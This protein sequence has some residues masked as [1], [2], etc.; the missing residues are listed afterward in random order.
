M[1]SAHIGRP[2]KSRAAAVPSTFS[3]SSGG[4]AFTYAAAASVPVPTAIQQPGQL[5][6]AGT[7]AVA[8]N[9]LQRQ[10]GW[11]K[12]PSLNKSTN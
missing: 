4:V 12:F 9:A 8:Q 7:R 5:T 11:A 3:V 2:D 10:K 1:S 6:K